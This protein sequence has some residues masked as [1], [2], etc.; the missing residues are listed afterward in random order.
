MAFRLVVLP[1]R[2]PLQFMSP[3]TTSKLAAR[4]SHQRS[5]IEKSLLL[6]RLAT[7]A[8]T[9]LLPLHHRKWMKDKIGEC[10]L[11]RCSH[12]RERQVQPHQE[13]ITLTDNSVSSSSQLPTSTG[14]FVAMYSHKRKLSRDPRRSQKSYSEREEHRQI[15][16]FLELRADYAA[17]GEQV[18]L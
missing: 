16:E 5:T 2:A 4:R 10:R 18:A 12:R 11:H 17:Q 1:N 6:V 3:T 7:V 13:C 9:S 8:S 15:L 14:K